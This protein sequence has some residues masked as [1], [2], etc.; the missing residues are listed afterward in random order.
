[1]QEDGFYG[2][3]DI[4]RY[5][6]GAGH[7]IDGEV[8][9]EVVDGQLVEKPPMRLY[10]CGIASIL[11]L[12]LGPFVRAKRYGRVLIE[13]MF[14]IDSKTK[15]DRRPDVA[16]V[17]YKRWPKSRKLPRTYTWAVVPDLVVE[18]V[19]R[20]NTA[21]QIAVKLREFFRAGVR[22]IWV[23]Y[24]EPGQVHVYQSPTRVRILELQDK[25]TGGRVLPGFRLPV[26]ALF[27][28]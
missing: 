13:A 18:V 16:F 14:R 9:Y 26:A 10:E 17:S 19:S 28:D 7:V 15:L 2:V 6:D 1:M 23:I 12:V 3:S 24:P 4:K 22:L 25:L 11:G 27:E 5:Y 21:E 8:P 20:S